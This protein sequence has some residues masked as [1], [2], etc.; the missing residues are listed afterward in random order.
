MRLTRNERIEAAVARLAQVR[1]EVEIRS[2]QPRLGTVEPGQF[3]ASVLHWL[4]RAELDE[5]PYATD[6]RDRDRWL[7]DYWKREPHLAGVVSSVVAIDKNRAWAVT[8]GRNQVKRVTTMLRE[9]EAGQGW[10]YYVTQQ[11][12][13]YYTTDMGALT[14]LGREGPE[15]PVR[16]LYT[17][18]S[19]LC[20][21]TGDFARPLAYNNTKDAW[22]AEDF[23]RVVSMPSPREE[24]H[25]LGFCAV[26]RALELTKLMVAV[27]EHDQEMLGAR[28]P[29]G[30][31]LLKGI[32]QEAWNDA[33]QARDA[34][35]TAR[36]Q[37][38]FGAVAVLASQGIDDID[39]KLVALSQLPAGFDMEK[40]TNLLMYGYALCFGYDPIEFWPVQ[41]GA[42]GRGRETELQHEKA[43]GKGGADFMLSLQDQLQMALPPTVLFEF[44]QRDAKGMILE[45]EVIAAW[46][47]VANALYQSG[48][49]ILTREQAASLLAQNGIIP[50]EWTEQEEDSVG[51][52]SEAARAAE[53]R[54]RAREDERVLRAAVQYPDEPIVRV[55]WPTGRQMLLFARGQE[56][57]GARVWARPVRRADDEVLYEGEDFT[58]TDADVTRAIEDGRRRVGDEFA[59]LLDAQPLSDEEIGALDG[60]SD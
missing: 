34:D 2:R 48:T 20:R 24:Y 56:L 17:L 37:E 55:E 46:V 14:E 30:L 8:G 41:A 58:I 40:M 13:N 54:R 5:P 3:F 21:L 22:A 60:S 9:A 11:A 32:S 19:T 50:P 45:A 4:R 27:Y 52:D 49:G 38:W 26:S 23:F 35:L 15:G 44:E 53:W 57:L 10:R 7:S 1:R 36:E 16:G 47:N 42:L 29:K 25:G 18:D 31:L 51:T 59:E 33:M 43:T 28:S 39:A 6:S 12:T